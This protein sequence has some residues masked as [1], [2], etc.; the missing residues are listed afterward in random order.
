MSAEHKPAWGAS[1]RLIAAE[2]WKAKSAAMGRGVTQALVEY[3][4][5][6]LGM[7]VLDV[8]TGTG[9]PAI[10]LAS[11]VGPS[12]HVTALDVSAELLEVAT[13]RARSRGLTNFSTRQADV[14]R[15]PFP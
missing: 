13:E 1:Y 9:E 6:R 7:K 11:Q 10:T 5:P 15:I 2:K 4:R 3:A 14:H 12:G 8:A